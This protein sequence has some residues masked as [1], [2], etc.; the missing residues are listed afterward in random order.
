MTECKPNLALV[1]VLVAFLAPAGLIPAGVL[2]ASDLKQ[3]IFGDFVT[4]ISL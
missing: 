2:V 4:E 1:E 3:P